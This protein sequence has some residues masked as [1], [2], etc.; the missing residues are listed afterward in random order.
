MRQQ[1]S[2]L[3]KSKT[4]S[5]DKGAAEWRVARAIVPTNKSIKNRPKKLN[6][7]NNEEEITSE[8]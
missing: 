6:K 3:D 7:Q 2:K 1:L 5:N 8:Q 4:E